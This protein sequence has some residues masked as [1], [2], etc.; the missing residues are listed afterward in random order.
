MKRAGWL[1]LFGVNLQAQAPQMP[2]LRDIAPPVDV[3]PYPAW[4]VALGIL[5]GL[6]LLGLV[7]WCVKRFWPRSPSLPPPTPRELALQQ[8][9]QLA[10]RLDGMLPYDFSILVSDVLRSYLMQQY[11]LAATRQTSPEFLASVADNACFSVMQKELL[12]LFLG[13]CDEVKFARVDASAGDSARLLEQATSFVK[14][15]A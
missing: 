5:I 7:V 14:G 6:L 13:R 3:F 2:E 8:L 10:T 9:Q 11:G 1:L 4:M 15:E 12:A